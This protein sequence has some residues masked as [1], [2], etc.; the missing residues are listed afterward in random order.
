MRWLA[1][2]AAFATVWGCNG[3]QKSSGGGRTNTAS[4]ESRAAATASTGDAAP[5]AAPTAPTPEPAV[6][7]EPPAE[8]AGAVELKRIAR[9]L[10]RPV[11]IVHAPGDSSGRLFIVEQAGKIL[12]FRDGKVE[13]TPFAD[14]GK[15]VTR[16]NNE[17]GL[18]GLAFHPKFADNGVLYVNYTARRD[19]DTRVVELTVDAGDP[20]AVDPKS[21]RELLKVE[22]PYGNHNAGDLQFGPDGLLYVGTGDGGAANDPHGNGQNPDALLAKMLR[23]D[24]DAADPKPV[25]VQIGLRNP[26]RYS[27]D[28]NTGDMYIADV[29]QNKWEW[30]LVVAAGDIDGHNFGW[31]RTEGMHCFR[32]RIG[33]D[34]TGITPPVIE[35]DHDT[36]CSITGGFV[37]RGKALPALDGVYFYADYCTGLL[38]SFRWRDGR[39]TDLWDWKPALDPDNKLATLSSFGQDADGEIYLVSLDGVIWKLVPK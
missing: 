27:F 19:G 21:A 28:R 8:I 35:Y 10:S 32:P 24:V 39:V 4:P 2:T 37:Y 29:G 38:R 13:P 17:Q 36:G 12:I 14:L 11:Q 31:N 9:G 1:V 6:L 26:W 7:T 15:W 16:R 3:A 34:R 23:L 25:I 5:A 33:C 22:Q 18:L 20:D 30:V